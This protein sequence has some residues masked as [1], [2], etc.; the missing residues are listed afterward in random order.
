MAQFQALDY[1]LFFSMLL[2]SLAIGV[3]QAFTG[4]RQKTTAEYLMGNRQLKLAPVALSICV[5][6]I[7]GEYSALVGNSKLSYSFICL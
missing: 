4:G 6:M 1:V 3:F 7:S 5:S 2:I